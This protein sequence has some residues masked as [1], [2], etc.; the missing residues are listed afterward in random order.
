[1]AHWLQQRYGHKIG[2]FSQFK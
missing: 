2:N 1:M